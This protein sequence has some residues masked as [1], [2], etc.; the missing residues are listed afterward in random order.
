[1]SKD[2]K[3]I[4]IIVLLILGALFYWGYETIHYTDNMDFLPAIP[5]N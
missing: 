1:M 3:I 2:T 4:A 5:N